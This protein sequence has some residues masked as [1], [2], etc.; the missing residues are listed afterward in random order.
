MSIY[1]TQFLSL[2]PSHKH[3]MRC[4]EGNK[5]HAITIYTLFHLYCA[6][7]LHYLIYFHKTPPYSALSFDI[8]TDIIPFISFM[9]HP[10]SN[11][12]SNIN[13]VI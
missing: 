11:I 10:H 6:Q 8:F 9:D 4:C 7:V 1:Q 3:Y 13:S 12:H 5:L 2:F